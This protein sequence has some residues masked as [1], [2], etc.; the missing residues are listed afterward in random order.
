VAA[1]R[2]SAPPLEEWEREAQVARLMAECEVFLRYGLRDK[3]VAQLKRVLEIDPRHIE[4]REK[5]KDAHL[6][7]DNVHSAVTQLRMLAE[8]VAPGDVA[9]ARAYLEE[10]RELAPGDP[11]VSEQID[12]LSR[13]VPSIAPDDE[14]DVIILDDEDDVLLESSR[15]APMPALGPRETS[16]ATALE[17]PNDEELGDEPELVFE[18]DEPAADEEDAFASDDDLQPA[19]DADDE[20]EDEEL[21]SDVA[22]ALE[23]ADFYLAQ[24]L[25]DEAREVLNDALAANPRQP[26]ILR[27]LAELEGARTDEVAIPPRQAEDK[28]FALAQ[29]L[30]E[31]A[32]TAQGPVEVEQVLRQFKEGVRRQVDA[33]DSATHYDLGIAYMEMGLHA[34]AIEAFKLCLGDS[35]KD[36]TAH[37]M[38]GLSYVAKGDMQIG[39]DH[40]KRALASP[41]R[42]PDEELGLWFE[43]GNAYELL[44]K[45]S[46]A[47]V[48][49]EKVEERN[50]DFRD[51][52]ARIERLG[53]I[54]SPQQETDE[55]DAMFDNMIIKE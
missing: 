16:L 45:A 47:L 38:L 42:K 46:E 8:I 40:F 26:A 29:K 12:A 19:E 1:E 10:A 36:C 22:E 39:I 11:A 24:K 23:E 15:P 13:K 21:P 41:V 35:E 5:L 18:D 34:E 6:R 25:E 9:Q 7:Q 51:V 44:G 48:F 49:Y 17:G 50:P 55:F 4:A 30:A 28:S 27:K 37:T 14:D 31:Q 52:S 53:H 20:G 33:S 2:R 32:G 3:V 54:K 43:I